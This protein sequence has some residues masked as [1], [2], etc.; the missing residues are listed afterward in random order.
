MTDSDPLQSDELAVLIAKVE[1]LWRKAH[2]SSFPEEAKAYEEKALYLMARARISEAM[3]DLD[4]SGDEI[5][6]LPLGKP[7]NGGYN[8]PAEALFAAVCAAYSCRPYYSIRGRV[9]QPY[10]VGFTSDINR[11]KFVWPALL[12]DAFRTSAQLKGLSAAQTKAMRRSSLFG[13][14]EAVTERFV[15]ISRIATGDA[16]SGTDQSNDRG[17]LDERNTASSTTT[18]LVFKSREEQV[19]SVFEAKPL[20]TRHG[21]VSG[22]FGGRDHGYAAGM[23]ADLSGG[24]RRVPSAPK[25]LTA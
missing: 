5:I 22:G 15:R 14:V 19:A 8:A 9:S 6:D 11:V 21:T 18:D 25:K 17:V 3:L 23:Q 10:A 2:S 13:Y 4:S 12:A 7:L 1:R 16:Q 20:V 24:G